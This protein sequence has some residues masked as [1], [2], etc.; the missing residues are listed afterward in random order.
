MESTERQPATDDA[1]KSLLY[2]IKVRGV[3]RIPDYIQAR[4]ANFTLLSYF[5]A[6]RPEKGIGQIGLAAIEEEVKAFLEAMPFG[7]MTLFTRGSDSTQMPHPT[8]NPTL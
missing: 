4:D 7:K 1:D 8:T 5:R 3:A 2:F 6:D